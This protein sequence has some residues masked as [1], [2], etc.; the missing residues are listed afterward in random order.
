MRMRIL[1]FKR[2]NYVRKEGDILAQRWMEKVIQSD[3]MV[4][5]TRLTL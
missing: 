3:L 5:R 4:H 1:S 2:V